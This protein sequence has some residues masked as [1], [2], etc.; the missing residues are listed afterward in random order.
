MSL[1]VFKLKIIFVPTII[2]DIINPNITALVNQSKYVTIDIL[3]HILIPSGVI[4]IDC[5]NIV[6]RNLK[7]VFILLVKI[8]FEK[9]YII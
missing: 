3:L 6:N 5:N 8:F 2:N 9:Y 1:I 4:I 7:S